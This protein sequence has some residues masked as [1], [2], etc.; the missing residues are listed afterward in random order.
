M[1]CSAHIEYYNGK[2]IIRMFKRYIYTMDHATSM[3]NVSNTD[4]ASLLILVIGR[5]GSIEIVVGRGHLT[6]KILNIEP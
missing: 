2:L 4:Y 1:S 3:G 5:L 6:C